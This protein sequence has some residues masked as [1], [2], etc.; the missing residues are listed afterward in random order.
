VQDLSARRRLPG[1][2]RDVGRVVLLPERDGMPPALFGV[3]L[4]ARLPERLVSLLYD[5]EHPL[6]P[7]AQHRRPAVPVP[8]A[9]TAARP[10]RRRARLAMIA[11]FVLV[12]LSLVVGLSTAASP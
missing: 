7:A 2:L 3:Q 12:S 1:R 8:A 5:A 6:R 11:L 9:G 10:Q 4:P